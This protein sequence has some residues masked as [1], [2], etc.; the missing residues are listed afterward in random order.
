MNGDVPP[1]YAVVIPH[2]NDAV[3][4]ER[5][6]AALEAQDRE[7]VEVVVAD[8]DSTVDLRDLAARFDWVRFVIQPEPGA[9]LARNA[10]VAAT[11]ATW[12]FFVDADC[13][14][15]EDWLAQARRIAG[16]DA[17]TVTGGRVDVFHET[18]PPCTGAEAFETVFAFKMRRYLEEEGFLGAGNLVVSR[19]VF[20]ATGGFR[21][22]VSED[23]E[24]SQRAAAAG[25]RLTYDDTLVVGHPSRKDWPSLRHKWKRVTEESFA[26]RRARGERLATWVIRAFL[27][28]ASVLAHAPRIVTCAALSPGEKWR[29]FGTLT[30]LRF[31]RMAWMLQQ[32]A[33]LK[34]R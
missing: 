11:S 20:R 12:L 14:P 7:E 26:L 28:P 27:M 16:G 18:P 21:D 19:E 31:V 4:L 5:C 17:G 24:W 23:V 9:G 1:R 29:A 33:G 2:Y 25:F 6:L 8:N 30:R 22:A 32:A 3:R 13:L 15:A 34:A 10:G